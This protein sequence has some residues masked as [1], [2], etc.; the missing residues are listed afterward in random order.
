MYRYQKTTIHS[1]SYTN[2]SV[3]LA[4]LTHTLYSITSNSMEH[5]LPRGSK[6]S[7]VKKF[8]MLRKTRKSISVFI[9]NHWPYPW[10]LPYYPALRPPTYSS[11]LVPSDYDLYS[12]HIFLSCAL[13]APSTFLLLLIAFT[14]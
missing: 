11:G 5:S 7:S 14:V 10:P 8:P 9:S 1:P 4:S 2:R 6:G 12:T 13:H 3:V